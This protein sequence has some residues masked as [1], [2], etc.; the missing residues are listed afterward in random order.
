MF[1]I[2]ALWVLLIVSIAFPPLLL[3]SIPMIL[4]YARR[5]HRRATYLRRSRDYF[6]EEQQVLTAAKYL[7]S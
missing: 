2:V 4:W 6:L 5:V 7:R 3:V 1:P